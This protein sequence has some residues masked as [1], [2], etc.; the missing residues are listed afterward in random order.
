MSR[1]YKFARFKNKNGAPY[2]DWWFVAETQEDVLAHTEKCFKPAMQHGLDTNLEKSIKSIKSTWCDDADPNHFGHAESIAEFAIQLESKFKFGPL[3]PMTMFQ[4]A[5]SLYDTV[6]ANRLKD[7]EKRPLYLGPEVRE[8]AYTEGNSFYDICE[9]VEVDE[10]VFPEPVPILENV[11]YMQWPGGHHWYAKLGNEDITDYMGNQ[12]WNTKKAAE[13]AA[14]WY[15]KK[16]FQR[17]RRV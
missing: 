12:K 8:F 2:S 15:I 7:V 5:N 14:Q 17:S 11:K 16:F 1:K 9:I 3:C 4:G 13:E 6:V 10:L